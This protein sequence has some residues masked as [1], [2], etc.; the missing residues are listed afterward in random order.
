MPD[1]SK[2]RNLAI[3]AH[4]DHGKTTLVDQLLKAGGTYRENQAV[5]ERAMD[6]MDLEREKGITIKAK[7]TSIHW[8]GHTI[9]IVDTPGHADFGAEVERVM[10]MVDG[11]LLVVDAYEGPQAQTRFVLRKALQEGLMPIVVV[12]KIDR[13]HA[14]A[15]AVK[16]QVLELFLELG[17][18][19]EQFEA[20]FVYGSARDG[21]FM[22]HLENDPPVDCTPLLHKIVAHIPAPKDADADGDFRMLISNIDWDDYVGR[23]AIGRISSGSVQKGDT[24]H[25]LRADGSRVQG[26]VTKLFEY[27]GLGTS[28]SA[29][30]EAGNI[31]GLAGFENVDIGET[32]VSNPEDE[33]LPFVAIDPPTISMEFSIND[34]PF[35]GQDGKYVTSRVIR[36]RLE[37]EIKTNI[38]IKMEDTD[39]AG[40][41]SVS[42]R[43]AMQI[44]VLVETMR[45]EGFEVCVSRPKVIT[46]EKDGRK[47]EPFE[48]LY[49]EVPDE[50]AN[51]AVRLLTS[52]KGVLEHMETKGTGRT[53]L[54]AYIPTRGIIGFEFE[55]VNLTS[56]HGIFSH[57]FREYA[58]FAGEI[59]TRQTG[60]LVS[61][62]TGVATPYSLFAL[63]DRGRLFVGAAEK[64]YEGQLIGENPRANDL[65]VN[66]CREKHLTN[67]RSANKNDS[68][69]LTPKVEFTLERAIEY[70]EADELVEA[71]PKNIRLRKR[72]LSANDRKRAERR[73]E[74]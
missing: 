22:D 74:S 6:S 45:R 51:G 57:L 54:Q 56:G 66:P 28:D 1:P 58:P 38:S 10:K 27:S 21:Y 16:D 63:E 2:F 37:R 64:V 9:N 24:V 65:P 25:L 14:N 41:F 7:N 62:E 70:I 73:A 43:G 5:Q 53:F 52:R 36:D 11:V 33:A 61:M 13:P 50:C 55:L 15:A 72:L 48:T 47:M 31:V 3:I 59:S 32:L 30:G 69:Q 46:I 60:T 23:I 18:T 8:H 17:A 49:I 67:H 12:N 29:V 40:I 19:D 44:A 20:P 39:A 68:I 71:T 26:K 34:G 42:A 35:A 4:V